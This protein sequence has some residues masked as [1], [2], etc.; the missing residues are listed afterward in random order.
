MLN[1]YDLSLIKGITAKRLE[2]LNLMGLVTVRDLLT[3]FPYRYENYQLI[4]LNLAQHGE[5]VTVEGKLYGNPYLRY[6]GQKRNMLTA[7]IIVDNRSVSVVWF[8]RGFL[9]KQLTPDRLILVT[10]KWDK[11]RGQITVAESSF[12]DTATLSKKGNIMPI[13]TVPADFYLTDL[14][15]IMQNALAQF[16]T[17]IT[18][19]LPATITKSYKLLG[20]KDAINAIHFPADEQ[21]HLQ[22]R[23]RLTYDELL[24]YQLRLQVN[25]KQA[26]E[27]NPG[28]AKLIINEKITYLVDSLPYTLTTDQKNVLQEIFTDLTS[29]VA[30]NRLLQGDVGSGK[31]IVAII[32]LYANYLAGFQGAI[33]V[34]TEIL[35]AQHKE[36]L[37]ELLGP[38]G[39]KI[40]ILT[41]SLSNPEQ[42]AILVGVESGEIDIVV[43]THSLFQER[44]QYNKLGLVIIDEQHRFGVEQRA[45]LRRKGEAGSPDLLYMSAT[46]IPRT[47]AIT[48]YG[49]MD[50]STIK[51]Y[52][53]GRKEIKT[54]LI[55]R[56]QFAK[57]LNFMK[58]QLAEGKQAYIISPLIEESEKLDLQNA[59]E[60]HREIS[61]ELPEYHIGLLHGRMPT[62]EKEEIISDFKENR[63][64][65]LVS[66]TVIEVGVNIKN[67]TLIIIYDADRFGLAQLH[68]LRGRVGRGDDQSYCILVADPTTDSGR[69][70]LKSMVE[71]NDGFEIAK[72]DLEIR[73][74]GDLLGVRQSGLPDFKLADV[75]RD[76]R[77]LET[78]A[79]DANEWVSD[80]RL[81]NDPEYSRVLNYLEQFDE[82]LMQS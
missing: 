49:E 44:V 35:A 2:R 9:K 78:A 7:Q 74:A 30:M 36:S 75:I 52:P 56:D 38:L 12:L 33:M 14:Q 27:E 31:T 79:R 8:N 13:Y 37:N 24:Q 16:S 51:H 20:L 77:T 41:S 40:G 82:E 46:P 25:K 80:E 54:S 4:D 68:Q 66:T 72:R 11:S 1:S 60:L 48:A 19:Y 76:Y 6:L 45:A 21:E 32:T 10:G 26:R 71:T 58:M 69:E 57:A 53:E 55:S 59:V 70:R 39:V 81:W 61:E 42:E 28:Q 23:R 62:Q 5:K 3:Y 22:A 73:G 29:E 43:G 64:Q 65:A 34:P 17:E 63:I 18:E 47:L 50:I 15:K 67:V